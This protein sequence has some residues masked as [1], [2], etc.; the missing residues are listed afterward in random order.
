M[1]HRN[2]GR[3]EEVND[4]FSAALTQV[5]FSKNKYLKT[6]LKIKIPLCKTN[7]TKR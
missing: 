4:Y 7:F 3:F 2:A 1:L 6:N 5:Q